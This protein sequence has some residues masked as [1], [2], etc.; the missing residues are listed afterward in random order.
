MSVSRAAAQNGVYGLQLLHNDN[1]AIFVTDSSPAAEVRYRAQFLFD[2]NS[3]AMASGNRFYLFYGLDAAATVVLRL[4]IR[5]TNGAYQVR[6]ALRN[7]G[8]L[9]ANTAWFAVPDASHSLEL[10]WAAASAPGVNDGGIRLF[11]DGQLRAQLTGVDNDTR[12]IESIRLGAVGGI[13]SGT[14]GTQFLD[15]FSSQRTPPPGNVVIG[16]GIGP[17]TNPYLPTISPIGA[18][19]QSDASAEEEIFVTHVGSG[20]GQIQLNR[21]RP[22]VSAAIPAGAM[23]QEAALVLR[24]APDYAVPAPYAAIGSPIE[25]AIADAASVSAAVLGAPLAVTF[26]DR[27]VLEADTVVVLWLDPTSNT[28]EIVTNVATP[29]NGIIQI[30]T[31]L[32]GVFSLAGRAGQSSESIFLPWITR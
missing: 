8:N 15:A 23:A 32:T 3:L 9:Y 24:Y 21:A 19:E 1:R 28:W 4:E 29:A 31:S 17:D 18:G 11:V 22:V 2:P 20:S 12:R 25:L 7:D 6:A 16:E 10:D 5:N 13:D 30:E 26:D 14:R 27:E